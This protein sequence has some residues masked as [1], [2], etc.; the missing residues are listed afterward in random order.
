LENR[1]DRRLAAPCAARHRADAAAIGVSSVASI[2]ISR[3]SR[4]SSTRAW[5]STE[6]MFD[7]GSRIADC[8]LRIADCGMKTTIP[9]AFCLNTPHGAHGPSVRASAFRNNNTTKARRKTRAAVAPEPIRFLSVSLCLC[10]LLLGTEDSTTEA[11]R[12]T[13]IVCVRAASR[14]SGFRVFCAFVVILFLFCRS[15]R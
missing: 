7:C 1:R 13:L 3:Y 8:G 14:R 6:G 4:V 11:R 9:S 12:R 10:S 5:V 15:A 2:D